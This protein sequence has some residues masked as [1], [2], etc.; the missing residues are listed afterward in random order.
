M[1]LTTR[2]KEWGKACAP[3]S[4]E[5]KQHALSPSYFDV[6][7]KG[8]RITARDDRSPWYETQVQWKILH[9][10]LEWTIHC[11]VPSRPTSNTTTHPHKLSSA[12]ALTEVEVV[13]RQE[14]SNLVARECGCSHFQPQAGGSWVQYL[15]QKSMRK[16]F[17]II[18]IYLQYQ[19]ITSVPLC[20]QVCLSKWKHLNLEQ[21][22]LAS[23]YN[24]TVTSRVSVRSQKHNRE[25]SKIQTHYKGC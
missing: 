20:V 5:N 12:S 21:Y 18:I 14:W 19:L 8:H 23:L 11:T 17:I 25:P 6:P 9:I 15:S 3:V 24:Y 13:K 2:E 7:T 22:L 1:V 16:I 10:Y 4:D